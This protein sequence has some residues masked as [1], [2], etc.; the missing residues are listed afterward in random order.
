VFTSDGLTLKRASLLFVTDSIYAGDI[1]GSWLLNPGS[2]YVNVTGAG[3]EF[4]IWFEVVEQDKKL[5]YLAAG[6]SA[7]AAVLLLLGAFLVYRG[8]GSWKARLTKV[9][10]PIFNAGNIALEVWDVYGDYF[11]YSLFV[12]RR[13]LVEVSWMAPLF[14][15]YTLFFGMACIVSLASIVLKLKIFTGFVMRMLGR[16]MNVLDHR[17]QLADLK[18]KMLALVLVASLEDL[19]MG[20][21]SARPMCRLAPPRRRWCCRYVG[22]VLLLPIQCGVHRQASRLQ[23][24]IHDRADDVVELHDLIPHARLQDCTGAQNAHSDGRSGQ[25]RRALRQSSRSAGGRRGAAPRAG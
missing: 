13:Q 24:Y 2:F 20:A 8:E 10:M 23:P 9:A 3:L 15:P 12:E 17:Q 16:A 19:P 4:A 11:S 18:Q 14:I 7:V 6:L 5:V 25:V 1:P 22:L 21:P